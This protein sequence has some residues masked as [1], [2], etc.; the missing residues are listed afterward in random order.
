[1]TSSHLQ[2]PA[3]I[4][5]G[6]GER[7]A[8]P[9]KWVEDGKTYR[10]VPLQNMPESQGAGQIL[11]SVGDYV[12]YVKAFM[13]REGPITRD[14]YSGVMKIRILCEEEDEGRESFTSARFYAAGWEV[15]WYRGYKIVQ[16]AGGVPG[17][18]SLHFFL[19]GVEFG[20]VLVGNSDEAGSVAGI[21]AR[22]MIDEVL[23]VEEEERRDWDEKFVG[24]MKEYEEGKGSMAEKLCPGMEEVETLTTPLEEYVGAYWNDGYR[25]MVVEVKD[26]ELFI[27]ASDRSMGFYLTLRHVCGQTTFVGHMRDYYDGTEEELAVQFEFENGKV[28]KLGVKDEE[29]YDEYVWYQRMLQ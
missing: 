2:P 15:M 14:V 1:M 6:L 25:E 7:I 9:Y 17:F 16:H 12:K 11:T 3:A 23:G 29:T 20:G 18:G 5:A 10:K 13:C 28:V 26:G 27:D 19:P 24:E 21:L 4:A 22:E 8:T